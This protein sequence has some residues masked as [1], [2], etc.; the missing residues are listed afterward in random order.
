MLNKDWKSLMPCSKATIILFISFKL[1]LNNSPLWIWF[2][3][4]YLQNNIFS[5]NCNLNFFS[6]KKLSKSL[7]AW[8][9]DIITVLITII[10]IKS[11]KL[12]S[13]LLL[14]ILDKIRLSLLKRNEKIIVTP[15]ISNIVDKQFKTINKKVFVKPAS[16]NN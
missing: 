13:K 3:L 4:L 11:N 9:D 12:I 14:N 10:N 5:R 6:N 16:W 8:I 15:N 1:Q 7:L 2:K